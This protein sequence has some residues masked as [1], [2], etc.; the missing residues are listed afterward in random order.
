M[1]TAKI[2]TAHTNTHTCTDAQAF[3]FETDSSGIVIAPK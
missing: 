1:K 2:I 3:P